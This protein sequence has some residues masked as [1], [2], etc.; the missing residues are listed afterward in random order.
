M[1]GLQATQKPPYVST[2]FDLTVFDLQAPN[3]KLTLQGAKSTSPNGALLAYRWSIT[4]YPAGDSSDGSS[5]N[6]EPIITATGASAAVAS[7]PAGNYNVTLE[8]WDTLGGHS[9]SVTGLS[10]D[11]ANVLNWWSSTPGFAAPPPAFA[12]RPVAVL[13][14]NGSR[15]EALVAKAR[16]DGPAV[17]DLDGSASH[18][19][20]GSALVYHWSVTQT[21]PAVREVEVVS[22]FVQPPRIVQRWEA[23]GAVGLVVGSAS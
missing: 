1:R 23:E 14:V 11:P 15:A 12:P 9:T 2:V 20:R 16:T 19:G 10:V 21:E 7:P 22:A 17:V 8:V 18:D 6:A 3:S 4:P 13:A 5:S